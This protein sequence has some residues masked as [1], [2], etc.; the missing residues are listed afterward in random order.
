MQN[1]IPQT[2]SGQEL[3]RLYSY[4]VSGRRRHPCQ[5]IQPQW[6][7]ALD[8]SSQSISRTKYLHL[9]AMATASAL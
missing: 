2:F 8:A 5:C 9:V 6:K 1:E 7:A 4:D 3:D